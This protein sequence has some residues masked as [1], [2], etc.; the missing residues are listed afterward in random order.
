MF[1]MQVVACGV[2]VF[3]LLVVE[4]VPLVIAFVYDHVELAGFPL[5]QYHHRHQWS[6]DYQH[7]CCYY[8]HIHCLHHHHCFPS[9]EVMW[10]DSNP[11]MML[12]CM[13]TVV[14]WNMW[15][16]YLNAHE[17]YQKY[18]KLDETQI[19]MY[20]LKTPL[21]EMLIDLNWAYS[22]RSQFVNKQIAQQ[23]DFGAYNLRRSVVDKKIAQHHIDGGVYIR[24]SQRV[25]NWVLLMAHYE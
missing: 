2:L 11:L 24:K 9:E 5:L 8:L 6:K 4:L 1:H 20:T 13:Q 15:Q 14:L 17:K 12:D 21:V 25:D 10:D 19:K 7:H 3:L 23:I 18:K 16:T 22:W